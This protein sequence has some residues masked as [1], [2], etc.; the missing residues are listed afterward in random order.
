[1]DGFDGFSQEEHHDEYKNDE[2]TRRNIQ[3]IGEEEPRNAPYKT[4]EDGERDYFY[5]VD[6]EQVGRHL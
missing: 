6:G 3:V 1:M 4:E 2:R 5:V